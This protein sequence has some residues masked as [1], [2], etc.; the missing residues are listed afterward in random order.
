AMLCERELI[1]IDMA[2]LDRRLRQAAEPVHAPGQQ[3]AVPMDTGMFW[4]LVGDVYPH[5]VAFDCFEGR[6]WR[7]AVIT[8]GFDRHPRGKFVLDLFG[9]QMELF[10]S[11]VH[12][13]GQ[14]AAC[15][16]N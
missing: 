13:V 16:R 10:D 14:R 8:P 1:T 4:K 15:R 9:D 6:T 5:P 12:S 3:Q 7:A 2:W 11:L